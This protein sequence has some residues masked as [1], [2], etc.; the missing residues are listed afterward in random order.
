MSVRKSR[1]QERR[2]GTTTF[3]T[4]YSYSNPHR[5][6][7]FCVIHQLAGQVDVVKPTDQFTL[8]LSLQLKVS[9]LTS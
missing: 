8:S 4:G 1:V 6:F 9:N 3:N 5:D 2:Q 7:S